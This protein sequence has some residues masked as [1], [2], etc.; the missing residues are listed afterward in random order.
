VPDIVHHRENGLL[1]DPANPGQLRDAILE[2]GAAPELRRRLGAVG[3]EFAKGFTAE[4]MW[5][6][7]LALYESVL[8]SLR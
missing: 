3:R 1:I 8:G 6:K 4:V 5:R 7:Y 2:L